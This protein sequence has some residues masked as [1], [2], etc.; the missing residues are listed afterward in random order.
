MRDVCARAYP[1]A[2]P[3]TGL[4]IF[5]CPKYFADQSLVEV[6]GAFEY[7]ET[8][9]RTGRGI[10]PGADVAHLLMLLL[11]AGMPRGFPCLFAL[12][13]GL[14]GH[15][16]AGLIAR[17]VVIARQVER[18]LIA[19]DEVLGRVVA[20]AVRRWGAVAECRRCLIEYGRDGAE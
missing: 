18:G 15:I 5:K 19:V 14:P 17:I 12:G 11:V 3:F 7:L 1:A 20:D 16:H 8:R 2:C 13:I 9:E 10:G 4:E 6:L